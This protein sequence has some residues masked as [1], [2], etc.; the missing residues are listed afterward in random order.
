M[1]RKREALVV[2]T[3]HSHTQNEIKNNIKEIKFNDKVPKRRQRMTKETA[4]YLR[5]LLAFSQNI[6]GIPFFLLCHYFFRV[7]FDRNFFLQVL[8]LVNCDCE[9]KNYFL[10]CDSIVTENALNDNVKP[11][12]QKLAAEEV[13]K[14]RGITIKNEFG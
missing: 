6:S 11:V 1:K 14:K 5:Q 2:V 7:V 8:H 10:I 3:L 13:E 12:S 4:R 9:R